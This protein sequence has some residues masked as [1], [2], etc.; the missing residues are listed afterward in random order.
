M[1]RDPRS[2]EQ[3]SL[4]YRH[5][6]PVLV[7]RGRGRAAR[8]LLRARAAGQAHRPGCT[9][10]V[11]D[12]PLALGAQRA[13]RIRLLLPPHKL[14]HQHHAHRGR[15]APLRLPH[16]RHR[17]VLDLRRHPH[18]RHPLH[19]ARGPA[20]HVPRL[21]LPRGFHVCSGP[22]LLLP[23]LHLG[24]RPW[25][26]GARV[27]QSRGDGQGRACGGECGGQLPHTVVAEGADVRHHQPGRQ[28]RRCLCRSGI[29][30]DRT[31][32][33]KPPQRRVRLFLR[34]HLLV[35]DPIRD[36]LVLW[37]RCPRAQS[38]CVGTRG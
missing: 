20:L 15:R 13:R 1:G 14:H 37:A 7:R 19:S 27:Q 30:A 16:A 25:V 36:G 23:H 4:P 34:R 10:P 31:R 28:L 18:N 21:V 8:A 3:R 22:H 33:Q 24:A 29:L 5:R 12:Y 9:H 38:A 2:V 17:P 6:R 11:R 35:C 26:G 32:G